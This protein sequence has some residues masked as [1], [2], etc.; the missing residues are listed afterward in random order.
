[1]TERVFG[2]NGDLTERIFV[3]NRDSAEQIFVKMAIRRIFI[4]PLAIPSCQIM[5]GL[6]RPIVKATNLE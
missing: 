4:A 6:D 1:L 5:G 3:K 2:K